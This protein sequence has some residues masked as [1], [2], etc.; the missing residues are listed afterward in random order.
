MIL[1]RFKNDSLLI[2]YKLL[3]LLKGGRYNKTKLSKK[4]IILKKIIKLILENPE[5]RIYYSPESYRIL[6]HNKEKTYIISFNDKEVKITNHTSFSKFDINYEF[7]KMLIMSAFERIESDMKKL[8]TEAVSNEDIF[9]D[10]ICDNFKNKSLE[11][12]GNLDG[13]IPDEYFNSILEKTNLS[14]E[15]EIVNF[16]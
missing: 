5:S 12:R 4:E 8:E 10:N 3:R 2:L 13:K 15:N 6:T 11:T 1:R 7:G 16:K 9:L 14:V